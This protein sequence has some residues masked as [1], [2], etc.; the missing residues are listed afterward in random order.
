MRAPDFLIIATLISGEL[1]R[2]VARRIRS[3]PVYR[4]RYS[5]S[6]PEGLSIA[7]QDLRPA[8]AALATEFYAGHFTFAME[9]VSTGGESP[10]ALPAPNPEWHSAL[11]SFRWLRHLRAADTDL[12]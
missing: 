4:W 1:F 2:R 10:F 11:H 9:T 8:D 6:T 7:P 5:G 12:A 3:G